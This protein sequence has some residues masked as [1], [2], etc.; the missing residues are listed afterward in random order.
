ML[1]HKVIL[2]WDTNEANKWLVNM[3]VTD[4]VKPQFNKPLTVKGLS[5]QTLLFRLQHSMKDH[6]NINCF[7]ETDIIYTD[8]YGLSKLSSEVLEAYK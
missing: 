2:E 8:Y 3:C 6:G 4:K 1:G 5:I 7:G